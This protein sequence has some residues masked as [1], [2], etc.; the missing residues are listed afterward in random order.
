MKKEEIERCVEVTAMY[1]EKYPTGKR[2][3]EMVEFGPVIEKRTV[4][5]PEDCEDPNKLLEDTH[6]AMHDR[7]VRVV[8]E[9]VNKAIRNG[10]IVGVQERS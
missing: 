2:N 9:M 3:Y 4:Y 10:R 6:Q 7:L 8:G 5:I 1:Q